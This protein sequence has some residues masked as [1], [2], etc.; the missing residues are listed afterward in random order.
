MKS[1]F[2]AIL[3]VASVLN[4]GCTREVNDVP[5]SYVEYRILPDEQ[6]IK[7]PVDPFSEPPQAPSIREQLIDYGLKFDDPGSRFVSTEVHFPG[8]AIFHTEE[9]HATV[10][11]FLTEQNYR[12]RIQADRTEIEVP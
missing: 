5:L 4:A 9:G 6:K 7:I 10:R 8:L 2:T 3:V 11:E 12:W 1:S